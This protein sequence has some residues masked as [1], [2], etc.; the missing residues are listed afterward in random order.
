MKTKNVH[1]NTVERVKEQLLDCDYFLIDDIQNLQ[2]HSSSQEIF[3]TVYNQLIQKNTQ[4]II[5]S[6][7]HPSEISGLQS[8]LISRFVSG[9]TI[10]ISKP[11]FETSKAIL[12]K[13]IKGREE[14]VN[15]SEDVIDYLAG[16]YS[17]D[18]RNLEGTLNR[19]IFNATLFN[20][21]VIDMDF[22]RKVLVKEPIVSQSDE[23]TIK[24]I[25]KA[26]TRFY[27]LSYKDLEGK[28]RQKFIANARHIC[29][30]LSRDLLHK[31]YV[32]IGQELGG[33][34][35]TT[36]SSSYERAKKLIQKDE[37]FKTAVEKIRSTLDS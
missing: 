32:S 28:C 30:Y 2:Q 14:S 10:S 35:H 20:P 11:E 7:M 34:D 31:S 12:K 4:I 16:K 23:L 17:N 36:I 24:K 1:G 21:D 15:M 3:F 5:T 27:G 26:V 25:K 19:L 6:D 22:T 37:A 29:V 33:R 9:L 8:R 13:K 18:V